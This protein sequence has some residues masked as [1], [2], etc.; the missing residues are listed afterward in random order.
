MYNMIDFNRG[1]RTYK[2]RR[3]PKYQTK[4][5]GNWIDKRKNKPFKDD[6]IPFEWLR[7]E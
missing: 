2:T 4:T 1:S 5:K 7:K 6:W 3:K